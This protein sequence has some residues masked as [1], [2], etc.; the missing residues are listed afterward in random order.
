MI[1]MLWF[2]LSAFILLVG[3]EINRMNDKIGR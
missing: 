2:Y 1:L 3:G